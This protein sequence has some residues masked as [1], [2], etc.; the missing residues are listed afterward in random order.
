MRSIPGRSARARLLS[1]LF[2][3]LAGGVSPAVAQLRPVEPMS[4]DALDN[5]RVAVRAGAAGYV[6]QRASLAGTRG[7]LVEMGTFAAFWPLGRVVLEL[8]GTALRVFSDDSTYARPVGGARAPDGRRRIDAG[9]QGVSTMVLLTDPQASFLAGLRFGVRLPTTDDLAG[10]GRDRTDFFSTLGG[11]WLRGGLDLRAEAGIGVFGTRDPTR[12]QVDPVLLAGAALWDAG[13]V[14]LGLWA[15]GQHDT[16]RGEPLRG[17][18]DLGEVR[19]SAETTGRPH[20]RVVVVRGFARHS[21]ALGL[22]AE[23]G[24][25][26]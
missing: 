17:T 10:L 24:V 4:W 22:Q 7:T 19:L 8:S 9:E 1:I 11:R 5:G 21:P 20:L 12:E 15:L 23:W 3:L 16:R 18:E 25:R 26:F 6:G 2:A 14:R 13:S